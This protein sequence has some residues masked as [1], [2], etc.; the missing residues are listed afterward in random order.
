M[1]RCMSWEQHTRYT[2]LT[3]LLSLVSGKQRFPIQTVSATCELTEL[4]TEASQLNGN[5]QKSQD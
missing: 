3:V 4:H 1:F 5:D 2:G